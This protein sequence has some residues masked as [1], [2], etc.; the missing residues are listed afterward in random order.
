MTSRA[1][2]ARPRNTPPPRAVVAAVRPEIDAG[3]VPIKRVVGETIVVEADAFSDGH[4]AIAVV[5]RH[6][7]AGAR[8]WEETPMVPHGNDLWSARMTVAHVGET[9]YT[10]AA[11]VDRFG[12]WAADL[13]KKADAGVVT[14][15]DLAIGAPLIRD[16]ARR[17]PAADRARILRFAR[18]VEGDASLVERLEA[19]LDPALLA[20][21]GGLPDRAREAVYGR[22]LRVR[23]D[24]ERAR[25]GAWYEFFPRSAGGDRTRGA[26]LRE[27]EAR[28]DAIAAMGFDV[29]YL[30]PIH[31]IGTSH[32]KGPNNTLVAGPGDPGSP[33]AIGNA[34]GGHK[35]VAP[36]LGTLEDFDRFREAAER[37][38]LEIALDIAFQCSPDH[39]YVREHP[40]WFRHRPDGTIQYAE[41]PPKKYEDIVPFEFEGAAWRALWEE[42]KSVILFWAERGVRIFRVDNPHTKPF[43]FWEWLIA[44]TQRTYPDLVFLSEAFTRPKVMKRLAKI[45]F[46]QSYTYFTWRNTKAE[47]TEYFTELTR[48]EVREYLRPNLFANTP[49]ILHEYLQVGGRPAFEARF[50][51]AA[52]LGASYGIY[53]PPFELAVA[54]ARPGTEEYQDSE[55]YQVRVWDH[56]APGHLRDVIARVNDARRRLAA[57]QANDGLAFHR[58][59]NDQLLCYSKSAGDGSPAVLVVVN[60]DPHHLQ[61]GWVDLALDRLGVAAGA[62]FQAHDVIDGT[63][64]L[65][66]G[67]RNYVRLD[68]AA[69][70]AHVFEVRPRVRT[71]RDFDYYMR[72]EA[73]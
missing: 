2:N 62:P 36:E 31:P 55:K 46:T 56:D 19:A 50:V 64:Y 24:R 11:W 37:R 57:L 7:A 17:A 15:L 5:L 73:R 44:A 23:V 60:L 71:E 20:A 16:A 1:R 70:A 65:W 28:L 4:D 9:E 63:T 67:G 59:D 61:H 66:E 33:W 48:T 45:G 12:T 41:N 52:T 42:L 13:R 47:L 68:P 38:G 49:D 72:E 35:A 39:P 54:E 58:T 34:D 43:A 22:V 40:E 6:R 21:A 25:T 27:A 10:V 8:R 32:R 3:A 14:D 26:T 18:V 29:V 53:G 69:H 51:L 30:P